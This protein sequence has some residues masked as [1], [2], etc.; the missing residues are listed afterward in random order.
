MPFKSRS[1]MRKFFA[2]EAEGKLPKGTART[3]AHHTPNLKKLPEHVKAA[4][5]TTLYARLISLC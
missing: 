5:I 1:Q 4:G 2:M 3:W